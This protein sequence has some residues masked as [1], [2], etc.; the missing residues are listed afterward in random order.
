[1]ITLIRKQLKTKILRM[2]LFFCMGVFLVILMLQ[3]DLPTK[4]TVPSR[5]IMKV[6]GKEIGYD[7][8]ARTIAKYEANIQTIREH[9]GAY[10]QMFLNMIG[11]SGDLKQTALDELSKKAVLNDVAKNI[12]LYL[13]DAFIEQRLNNTRLAQQ[14]GLTNLLPYGFFGQHGLEQGA[15][16][17]YL[18]H[19]RLNMKQFDDL[20]HEALN[21]HIV[22]QLATIA[23]YVPSYIVNDYVHRELALRNYDIIT[24]PHK[25]ILKDISTKPIS[26]E[27]LELFFNAQNKESKRYWIPDMRSA[28]VWTFEPSQYGIVITNEEMQDYYEKYRTIKYVETPA[29]VQ[30]RRILLV[31]SQEESKDVVAQRAINLRKDLIAQPSIFENKAREYSHDKESAAKGGLLPFFSKGEKEQ[32]FERK[33][34]MLANNGDIS[35]V[36]ESSQGY[37]IVQRVDKKQAK[38]KSFDS[39]KN[40]IHDLLLKQAFEKKFSQDIKTK[41]NLKKLQTTDFD[42][43]VQEKHASCKDLPLSKQDGSR[44]MQLI[45]KLKKNN[46]GFYTQDG[47]GYIVLLTEVR[48]TYEPSL[49]AVIKSVERDYIEQQ[50]NFKIN[51]LT[52]QAAKELRQ[53]APA[54][55]VARQLGGVFEAT[56]FIGQK[57]DR[58]KMLQEQGIPVEKMFQMANKGDIA[59]MVEDNGYVLRVAAVSEVSPQEFNKKKLE[60]LP[61]INND[62]MSLYAQGFVAS[63]A[64]N[65]KI[66]FSELLST[67]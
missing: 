48:P 27:S 61:S 5:W 65:A 13:H 11:L 23:A 43:F 22:Y 45:F 21:Q 12:P 4:S 52:E 1:M 32:I 42:L 7:L 38:F 62:M 25:K 60:D 17:S 28:K 49:G 37:E 47:V 59:S 51:Q 24:F 26:Q 58:V 54:S 6:D 19:N 18:C 39:V 56:G 67:Q 33:A 29:Q 55:E 63:L 36:F 16:S 15:L 50:A 41:F 31:P 2:V 8:F 10:A 34:F 66:E 46:A 14:S 40:E 44:L 53:G 30:V 35:D 9:Y 57:D 64:R 3:T 20:V